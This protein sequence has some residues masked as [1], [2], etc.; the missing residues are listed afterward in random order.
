MC[1]NKLRVIFS[2]FIALYIVNRNYPR[3]ATMDCEQLHLMIHFVK[4]FD[5][6]GK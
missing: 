3:K 4:T 1:L 5:N 6:L 2:I